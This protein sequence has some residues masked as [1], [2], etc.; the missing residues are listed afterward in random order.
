MKKNG[1]K[2][3]YAK[4]NIPD[5]PEGI[6]LESMLEGFAE[7]YSAELSQKVKRGIK[8]NIRKGLSF[9]GACPFGYKIVNKNM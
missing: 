2:I 3:F 5:G 4:E 9:G 7:Y 1:I 6:I 8:E